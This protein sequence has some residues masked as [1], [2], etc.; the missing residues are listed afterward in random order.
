M[1]TSSVTLG[2]SPA[3]LSYM[4]TGLGETLRRPMA[5]LL[6]YS[7]FLSSHWLPAFLYT[8]IFLGDE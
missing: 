3:L 1:D 2:M 6:F 5:V 8:C 7:S 4:M